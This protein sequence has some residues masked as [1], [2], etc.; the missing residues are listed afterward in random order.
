M[1]EHGSLLTF[2]I[3]FCLL[4]RPSFGVV[5][6]QVYVAFSYFLSGGSF[7]RLLDLRPRFAEV[8]SQR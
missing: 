6:V 8:S 1:L 4:P 2:L 7:S 3:F 5:T